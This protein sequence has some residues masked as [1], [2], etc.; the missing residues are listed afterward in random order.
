MVEAPN[1]IKKIVRR[2][3]L[4]LL[5]ARTL[6]GEGAFVR[7]VFVYVLQEQAEMAMPSNVSPIDMQNYMS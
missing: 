6:L 3:K 2:V 5:R 4:D 7:C 1:W